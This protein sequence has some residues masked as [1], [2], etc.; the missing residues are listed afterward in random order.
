MNNGF[1]G[2]FLIHKT[3]NLALKLYGAIL[4]CFLVIVVTIF[5]FLI[6]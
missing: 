2:L 4:W 1:W 5:E 3:L 6:I